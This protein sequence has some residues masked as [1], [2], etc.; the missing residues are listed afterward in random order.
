MI[1]NTLVSGMAF[2]LFLQKL[3]SELTFPLGHNIHM[4][5]LK[6]YIERETCFSFDSYFRQRMLPAIPGNNKCCPPSD[7]LAVLTVCPEKI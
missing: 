4:L 2:G 6:E 3:F 7:T 5:E 1:Y